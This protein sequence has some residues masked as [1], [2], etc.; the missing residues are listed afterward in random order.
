MSGDAPIHLI[1]VDGSGFIFRAFHALPPMTAPDG[2]PVNAVFGFTNMLARLLRDHVGT[3]LAVIFDAGRV[4]FRNGIY[5]QY[6]AH[7]PEPPEELRPQFALVRD[8][9]AAFG[10]PGIEE[11]GWEADDLIA[12]YARLVTD[13]GG[14]CT[15]VS[16]DKD[17]MQLIRPGVEMLDPIRQKPIGPKEV[18][19]KFG[20]TPDKVIDVQ[21]LIG[22]SVDNVPGV[23]GIGPKTASALIA[24]Y[25][26]L[27]AI[28][29][30]AP[31]MKPSKRRDSLIEHAERAR[32]SRVLVTL[33]EDAPCPLGLEDLICR[34]PDEVK[35]GEWLQSMG[36]RSLLHRMGM[37]ES[38]AAVGVAS[39]APAPA[40]A[41]AAAPT[42]SPDRAP[43]G[44]YETV[45]TAGALETWV[46]EARTAGFC[47]IDTETDGLDPLRA[48]LVGISLAV[49][50]GRACYIPLAHTAEPPPP[51]LLPDLLLE[52]APQDDAPDPVGPQL[53]TGLALAILGPLLA[54]ASVLKIFQNAKFDLLVL[55]RAGAPQP[56]PVDDT[57]LISYAQF[58]GR[59]GQGMDELSRLYLGH[60]PIPYDEVTGTGR[61]RVPFA[62]VDVARATAYAA[63]DAD[64]TL[65]LWLSLRPTLR[66]HH[67]LALY[68]E[69]ER[70]LVAV[71]ADMERAGIAIDV[72]EL[73]RMSADFA[74]RM[75][76]MEA[77]IQALAGRSFNVG[78]PKQLG[79]IL[80]DEMGLPGG[81]RMKSGAWGTDSSVLQDLA[82][83]GHD[84]PGRI[85]AWR[86][87]AKLKSTYAD[88][89]VKQA[90]P[91]TARVHT[92][93][94]MAI[95]STGRLSSNEP[96]L[97]NIPIRTEEG[98]RI[99]RAFVAAPGHVLLSADYSQIELRLLAHVADIP[100]LREAFALGQDIHAR[101][102]SEVFGIPIEGMDPLTRRRAKA[103]NF[104][105][106]YGI[107][108]FGLGRQLGIPPGEARAYI[109]AYFARYP[110]I[111]AYMETVKQEA[112]DQGYVTTPFGRRCWVPGIADR[113]A[114]RRAYAER[115]AINA[116]LQGGA[117]DIIK[118]AM[119]RLPH[120]LASAGLDGRL[121]L[122][123]HDELLFEVRA[124]QQD[125]L[126]ALVKQVMESA[127]SLSVPLVVETGTGANW[128]DAH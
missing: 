31:A 114:V 71:L 77:E 99:R 38:A 60:T 87:L 30:G 12:A 110:G 59:H 82:D 118:R 23:P 20:V 50:P 107:S 94:Q 83:Q 28:L 128:A 35:L 76:Q 9:T 93:F 39:S 66:I 102:A 79:E 33:R 4:T 3:H 90:D 61:N 84:L 85:L 15:V 106:I 2:T 116:P 98:G 62:R 22:D 36:F 44:P 48:G 34:D 5:D 40:A 80:F 29:D 16:S 89:L 8:A 78:S 45:R 109:D 70:P 49:A 103:I 69:L 13:A 105:I 73:R 101:T 54:D 52:P 32:L 117:A 81:K 42:P 63:E 104:G 120:A 67:A 46:A 6:K 14:R 123:V 21:A 75:A 55:T 53:E 27:D 126:S 115:Q 19:A 74:T 125:A 112:K 57:M 51:Q 91:D 124:G 37:K 17:L 56:A 7:R 92:S 100:A 68:E 127:A 96:N 119:V 108:A 10:V 88:A 97:Q 1:L 58:A 86:Q 47:A 122:Q 64:V 111:R 24:E 72:V 43:Y 121:L 25:G 26:S 95:T 113:S 11:A 65:R 18:E 41:V